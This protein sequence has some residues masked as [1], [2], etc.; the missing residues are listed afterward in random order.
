MEYVIIT[1]F[2]ALSMKP[3]EQLYIIK[4]LSSPFLKLPALRSVF[5]HIVFL[6]G[7]LGIACPVAFP[8][9]PI[10]GII[11]SYAKIVSIDAAD[12]VT[13]DDASPFSTGDTVLVIQMKGVEILAPKDEPT[14]FGNIQNTKGVGKYE[15]ILVSSVAGNQVSFINELQFL[16]NYNVSGSMQLVRVRGYDKATVTGELTCP[17]WDGEKGGVLALIVGNTLKLEAGI[18]VSGMGF[19]GGPTSASM[20]ECA[21][22][23]PGYANVY[24]SA[25]SDSAGFKGEGI[26]SEVFPLIPLDDAYA[27]GR[28]K[29]YNGGGG[30]NAKYSGGGGG[31]NYG[32][33][34][35]GGN[36]SLTCGAS[37]IYGGIG[38]AEIND[39][40]KINFTVNKRLFMGGGGGGSTELNPGDGTDGGKGGGLLIVLADSIDGNSSQIRS[41]GAGVTLSASGTG[42][43]GGGGAGGS[44]ILDVKKYSA[45][46]LLLEAKGGK[47]GDIDPVVTSDCPGPG[48]GGGGGLIWSSLALTAQISR[49][50][51]GGLAGTAFCP[52]MFPGPGSAGGTVTGLDLV[53]TGFL[54]NTIKVSRSNSLVDTICEGEIPSP[55]LGSTPKG[56]TL[57]YTITWEKSTD[58]STW[59]LIPGENDVNYIPAAPLA[60]TTWYRRIIVDSSIPPV[61]DVSKPVAIYVHPSIQNFNIELTGGLNDT[62]ICNGQTPD[63]IIQEPT[64]ILGGDGTYVYLWEESTDNV[65]FIPAAGVNTNALYQAPALAQTTWYRRMVISGKCL[66][67]SNTIT[68]TVLPSI[69]NN[70]ILADQVI[71]EGT[72][73]DPLIG[74]VPQDGEAGIYLYKWE[75]SIDG[76]A[77]LDAF[78]P[79]TLKDYQPDAPGDPNFPAQSP[80]FF[81]RVVYSGPDDVCRDT[82]NT[83]SLTQWPIIE[84][85]TFTTDQVI[86]EG[87]TP[88]DIPASDPAGG[89]PASYL[90]Q[91]QDSIPGGSWQNITGGTNR[92]FSFTGPLTDSTFIRRVVSSDVCTDISAVDTIS[93]HPS[94]Q[95]F[96]IQTISGLTDTTICF[97]QI[98]N[99]LVAEPTVTSGGDGIYSYFWEESTDGGAVWNPVGGNT[100]GLS[101]AALVQTTRYRRTVSSGMCSAMSNEV[102]INVLPSIANNT[103]PAPFS[104]CSGNVTT[105]DA[106]TPTGGAG[107]GTFTYLWEKSADNLSWEPADGANTSEDYNTPALTSPIWYRRTVTSGP[108]GCCQDV[109]LS[110]QVGIHPL[111]TASLSDPAAVTCSGETVDLDV[112]LTGASPWSVIVSDGTSLYTQTNILTNNYQHPVAPVTT[113]GS[114]TFTFTVSAVTDGNGCEAVA[115]GRTG[116]GM[117][118]AYGIPQGN[119][120]SDDEVCGLEYTMQASLPYGSG[121]WT[122]PAAV[123]D[124]ADDTNPNKLVRV[125]SEGTYTF[126]WT[127]SNGPCPPSADD[128]V[129]TFWREV[130]PV[131]LLPDTTLEPY[132]NEVE[133][134]ALVEEPIIGSFLWSGEPGS[135]LLFVP[136]NLETTLVKNLSVGEQE[137][138]FTI[139]NGTCREMYT[140]VVYVPSFEAGSRGL[141]PNGDGKNDYFRIFVPRD[142]PNELV[143]F[144]RWGNVVYREKDFM[145]SNT[146]GW[147]GRN[148]S[149]NPLPN[150]T[151][152]YIIKIEGGITRSGFILI[153]G[154]EQ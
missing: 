6:T 110:V 74:S 62:I 63:P 31:G 137:V 44:L 18:D 28:G 60:D 23:D 154:V 148:M 24:F 143:I 19:R 139:T 150:D 3:A 33:G 94:L 17:P 7:M 102:N 25:G 38:G 96:D 27:K 134:T 14:I 124:L 115:A 41:N 68:L 46:S 103:L 146:Q 43:A 39:P 82:S 144:N 21:I 125:T 57:P 99:P 95:H 67:Y 32:P 78:G 71:C 73:F 107:G 90:F 114:E 140:L 48:G 61:V 142:K 84:N 4:L 29:L 9:T 152:Y 85:N 136:E 70:T 56:G 35:K 97:G 91:W 132:A 37:S 131:S 151:Y 92:D 22:N 129:I 141:T 58:L 15:F 51:T 40:V 106:S 86:C 105:I 119:A 1:W 81:R 50:V 10:S 135:N 133:L 122:F 128:V 121:M 30:G 49:N 130:S 12:R 109:S 52:N 53:L 117:V 42:G 11:N 88:L 34:G 111:P 147:D 79:I 54:F 80:R 20:N 87:D 153:R 2:Q 66:E 101:P 26:A 16:G 69:T 149:G 123:A 108:A 98:P 36:E 64:A 138:Y 89:K 113:I 118:T 76:L 120:G 45:A 65:N 72:A 100:P 13:V 104:V 127:V 8:Q 5:L 77:W 59:S 112:S 55:L 126:T 93:V 116:Q 83:L 47:G 75:E 145:Q